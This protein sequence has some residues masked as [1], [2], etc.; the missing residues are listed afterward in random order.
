MEGWISP[1]YSVC[2]QMHI[3]NT[4]GRYLQ[5]GKFPKAILFHIVVTE[6]PGV[7]IIISTGHN[8]PDFH[9]SHTLEVLQLSKS[10]RTG[11]RKLT[12]FIFARTKPSSDIQNICQPDGFIVKAPFQACAC[13][14]F[15]GSSRTHQAHS[16][17]ADVKRRSRVMYI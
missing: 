1:R 13:L 2:T 6:L 3:S 4:L 9:F 15:A 11:A 7:Y 5:P 10:G 12:Y 16:E 17:S 8:L 14:T